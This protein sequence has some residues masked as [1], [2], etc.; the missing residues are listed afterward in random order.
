M[1]CITCIILLEQTL[2]Y[3]FIILI[4]VTEKIINFYH[5]FALFIK[6]KIH[7]HENNRRT[8]KFNILSN[9]KHLNFEIFPLGLRSEGNRSSPAQLSK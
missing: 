2:Q 8:L 1:K 9:I 3:I 4:Q 5:I 7:S 6:L